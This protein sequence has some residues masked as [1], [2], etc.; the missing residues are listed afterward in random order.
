[1][2][3]LG[4]DISEKRVKLTMTTS[5][6][7]AILMTK[8]SQTKMRGHHPYLYKLRKGNKIKIREKKRLGLPF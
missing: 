1:M 2:A 4:S 3:C 6:T 5:F 7:V 8:H